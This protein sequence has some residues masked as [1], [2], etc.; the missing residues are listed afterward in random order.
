L[1]IGFTGIV[2]FPNAQELQEIAKMVPLDRLL[3]ETDSPYLAPQI[4]RGKRNE[5]AFVKHVAEQISELKGIPLEEVAAQT[6]NN[7]KDLFQF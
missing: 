6:T 4:V 3:I 5:P 7:T 1:Y 2:T